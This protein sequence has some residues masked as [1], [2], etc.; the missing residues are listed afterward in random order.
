MGM[1]MIKGME[2]AERG[3]GMATVTAMAD[4]S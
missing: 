4:P 3:E 1:A 2:T